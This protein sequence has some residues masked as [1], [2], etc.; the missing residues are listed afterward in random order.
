M[1][2]V[3]VLLD[4]DVGNFFQRTMLGRGDRCRKDNQGLV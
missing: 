3:R 2:A 4:G 1:S